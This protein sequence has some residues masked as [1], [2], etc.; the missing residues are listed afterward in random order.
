MSSRSTNDARIL[1]NR[2]SPVVGW[3][4]LAGG[5]VFLAGG[6]LH[7]KEDPPGVSVREHLRVMFEDSNWY[8]AHAVLFVGIAVLAA[9]LVALARSGSLR[10]VPRAHR[11]AVVAAVASTVAAPA[12]LLHLV[13]AVE[14]DGIAAGE[15]TPITDVQVIV[16]TITVPAFGFSIAALA[17][18]GAFTRSV[19]DR[20]TAILGAVGGVGY[21]LAGATFLFTDALNFLFPLASGIAVWAIAAG[22]SVLL[23]RRAARLAE[24]PA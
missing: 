19:G 13:S 1:A 11:A 9:A 12:M 8:A 23:R 16:E 7:P 10:E 20:V 18:I 15:S 3:G 14:A 5:V 24:Q 22:I 21:G 4:L 17:M 6:P 2:I